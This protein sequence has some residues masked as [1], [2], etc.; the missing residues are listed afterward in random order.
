MH[1]LVVIFCTV[2]GDGTADKLADSLVESKLAACVNI[3][4]GIKSVYCWQGKIERDTEK[5]LLIKTVE[6]NTDKVFKF[7]EENHPYDVAERI[8]IVSAKTGQDYLKW[9]IEYIEK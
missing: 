9:A 7:I 4:P 6:Q 2:P 3:I 8:S 1:N 5:L